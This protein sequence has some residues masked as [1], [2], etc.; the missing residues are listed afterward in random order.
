MDV[1]TILALVV[2]AVTVT[3]GYML[4]HEVPKFGSNS[5]TQRQ[6]RRP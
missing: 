2:A 6:P 5:D 3:S 1:Y 4:F